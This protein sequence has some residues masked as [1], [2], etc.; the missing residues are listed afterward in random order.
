MK[1]SAVRNMQLAEREKKAA[2]KEQQR[3][4]DI[5]EDLKDKLKDMTHQRDKA[6][7]KL[8]GE[9]KQCQN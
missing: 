1:S 8:K 5:A 4:S 6:L 3:L 9:K 7:K 2:I